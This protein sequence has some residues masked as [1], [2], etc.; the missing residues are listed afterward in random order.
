MPDLDENL[1]EVLLGDGF[2]R[3]DSVDS[4]GGDGGVEDEM[5]WCC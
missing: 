4:L 5:S 2:E 3:C 1:F